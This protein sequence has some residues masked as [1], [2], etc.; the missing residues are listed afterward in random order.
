M[1]DLPRFTAFLR[2]NGDVTSIVLEDSTSSKDLCIK[3]K[4]DRKKARSLGEDRKIVELIDEVT[5][6]C[7]RQDKQKVWTG[8]WS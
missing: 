8:A 6:K 2:G 7:G 3:K 4:R 5:M 1:S